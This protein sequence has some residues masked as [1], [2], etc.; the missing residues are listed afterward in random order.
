MK[1]FGWHFARVPRCSAN[2]AIRTA[3]SVTL[4][5]TLGKDPNRE[6]GEKKKEK[7]RARKRQRQYD[8]EMGR[9]CTARTSASYMSYTWGPLARSPARS[10]SFG[11][12][13]SASLR[14]IDNLTSRSRDAPRDLPPPA[15]VRAPRPPPGVCP[16]K[17][18]ESTNGLDS[19]RESA[20]WRGAARRQHCI[21]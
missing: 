14:H 17:L 3:S 5:E 7:K 15:I 19:N 10:P 1:S 21:V 2:L 12:G 6:F 18:L 9:R 4:G 20:R 8:A 13:C 11:S 16:A